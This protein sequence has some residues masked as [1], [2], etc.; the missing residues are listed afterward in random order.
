MR[1]AEVRKICKLDEAGDS[2]VRVAM[3]Q[4]NLLARQGYHRVLKAARTITDLAGNDQIQSVYLAEAFQYQPKLLNG[5]I[6][7]Q[8]LLIEIITQVD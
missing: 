8:K 2:L 4:L 7:I 1:V 3:S 5:V 6:I